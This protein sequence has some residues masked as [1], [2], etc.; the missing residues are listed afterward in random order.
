MEKHRFLLTQKKGE[1]MTKLES[2][3]KFVYAKG[4]ENYIK[5]R[6][7]EEDGLKVV[8]Q[9]IEKI[10]AMIP[11]EKDVHSE[12]RIPGCDEQGGRRFSEPTGHAQ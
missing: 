5:S 4:M 2:I 7:T 10:K 1:A 3:L 9:A 12:G 8:N 11:E 6:R